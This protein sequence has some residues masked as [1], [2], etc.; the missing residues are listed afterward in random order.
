M[1]QQDV[2]SLASDLISI[3]SVNPPGDLEKITT[4]VINYLKDHGLSAET[5]EAESGWP[6]IVAKLGDP[7]GGPTLILNGHTD[8]V[9]ANAEQWEWDPFAGTVEDGMIQGRGA[10][11]M[12][13]GLAGIIYAMGKLAEADVELSGAVVLA[14]VPDEESGGKYG[15]EWLVESGHLPDA[16][17]AL[18]AEP[19][20]ADT[21]TTGQKGSLWLTVESQGSPTHGSLAPFHGESAILPLTQLAQELQSLSGEPVDQSDLIADSVRAHSKDGIVD[22]FGVKEATQALDHTTI[23]VGTIEGGSKVNVV[24]ETASMSIDIRIPIG[25]TVDETLA[26]V[27]DA[28]DTVDGGLTYEIQKAS[29]PNFTA[30]DDELVQTLQASAGEV[31]D[32]QP[33]PRLMWASSDARYFRNQGIPTVQ[34][35][36][37]ET[38]GIHSI[39]EQVS[40]QELTGMAAVYLEFI[41]RFMGE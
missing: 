1:D 8:V 41:Q 35:G 27:E 38:E 22:A 5:Y 14:I 18:V 25:R 33:D 16:D 26:A 40:V 24:P 11:D 19:S 9:P 12:K 4:Y 37:A 36:P 34:Y 31:F 21:I 17:A 20:S 32:K 29:E 28:I 2:V 10:S 7:S 23:N 6:N 15:T 13:G 3:P 39:D 30:H